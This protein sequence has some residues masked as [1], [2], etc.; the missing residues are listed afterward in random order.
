VWGVKLLP[1][2]LLL[3]LP[4]LLL[5][6]ELPKSLPKPLPKSFGGLAGLKSEPPWSPEEFDDD[7][8]FDDVP[9]AGEPDAEPPLSAKAVV[10]ATAAPA[11]TAAATIR[12][13]R[14][15]PRE[16]AMLLPAPLLV[17]PSPPG[18]SPRTVVTKNND[19]TTCTRSR[20]DQPEPNLRIPW[21]VEGY[22]RRR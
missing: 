10:S 22:P 1:P 20:C 14:A 8:G 21:E 16:F 17:V 4:P 12:P 18:P 15:F 7:D 2:L 13:R 3:P 9:D 19:V 5:L 6:P 11:D